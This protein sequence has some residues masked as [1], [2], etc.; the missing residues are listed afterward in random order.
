[1]LAA[2]PAIIQLQLSMLELLSTQPLTESAA[3]LFIS[4]VFWTIRV[5]LGN[6]ALVGGFILWGMS[7]KTSKRSRRGVQLFIA[8]LVLLVVFPALRT[9]VLLPFAG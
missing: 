5:V 3:P 8:G 9:I 6:L 7:E 2:D 4:S 1:M